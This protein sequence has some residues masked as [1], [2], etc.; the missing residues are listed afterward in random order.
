MP[1]YA[2][3]VVSTIGPTPCPADDRLSLHMYVSKCLHRIPFSTQY[4]APYY[5]IISREWLA[6]T[7]YIQ[8]NKGNK[9]C[10]YYLFDFF[11]YS[12]SNCFL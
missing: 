5:S 11:S 10:L 7:Y 6:T 9:T 12:W 8:R 1:R 3:F 2:R 4:W